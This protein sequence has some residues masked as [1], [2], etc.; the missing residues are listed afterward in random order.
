MR[1]PSVASNHRCNRTMISFVAVTVCPQI[2]GAQCP[3]QNDTFPWSEFVNITGSKPLTLDDLQQVHAC[4]SPLSLPCG[5]RSSRSIYIFPHNAL[6]RYAHGPSNGVMVQF[7]LFHSLR[8][9]LTCT[10]LFLRYPIPQL[11]FF[12]LHPS[13]YILHASYAACTSYVFSLAGV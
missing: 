1:M 12:P 2:E 9:V 8:C 10:Q 7:N 13:G 4:P 3:C 6:F 11:S 5:D